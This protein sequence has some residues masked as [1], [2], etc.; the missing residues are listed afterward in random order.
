MFG[1][2]INTLGETMIPFFDHFKEVYDPIYTF[3]SDSISKI[4]TVNIPSL[5]KLFH[6]INNIETADKKY[7]VYR[8]SGTTSAKNVISSIITATN[9]KLD[10]LSSNDRTEFL[11]QI[12]KLPKISLSEITG[13]DSF[14]RVFTINTNITIPT[15]DNFTD[16]MKGAPKKTASSHL[17]SSSN[18]DVSSLNFDNIFTDIQQ[19]FTDD[20][21]VI[22]SEDSDKIPM[23]LYDIQINDVD[24]KNNT[25][26]IAL[27]DNKINSI[28]VKNKPFYL[29]DL[30]DINVDSAINASEVVLTILIAFKNLMPK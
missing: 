13:S 28:K 12:E 22:Y 6:I 29:E 20:I 30:L 10:S 15:K 18:T 2:A 25:I 11:E 1:G 19:F 5:I 27:S 14:I 21:F 9:T 26:P 8:I 4:D 17:V 7:G 16:P 24:I 3:L 23:N